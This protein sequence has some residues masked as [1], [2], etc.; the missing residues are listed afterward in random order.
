[1]R[2]SYSELFIH[3]VWATSGRISWIEESIE[4]PL[5][6]AMAKKCRE[7]RCPPIAIGGTTDHVHLL[8]GL[9]P[10]IAVATLVK[11]VKG[12]SAHLLTHCLLPNT[13]FRWQRGYSAF[14]MRK[15]DVEIVRGYIH[16]QKEHH[17]VRTVTSEW[18][19]PDE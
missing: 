15:G 5:Y 14:S 10:S 18:E 4:K 8:V 9:S 16:H 6:G 12:V 1:M 19:P 3:V 7:L 2:S 11:E 13:S 17:R